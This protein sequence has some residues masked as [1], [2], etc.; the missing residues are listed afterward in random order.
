[1]RWV[2]LKWLEIIE[3]EVNEFLDSIQGKIVSVQMQVVRN[4]SQYGACHPSLFILAQYDGDKQ[5]I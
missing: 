3:D 2:K 5:K 1:M 4:D